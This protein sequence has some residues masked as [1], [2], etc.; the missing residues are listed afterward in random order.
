MSALTDRLARKPQNLGCK[1]PAEAIEKRCP[2]CGS[3][4]EQS[5]PLW[6]QHHRMADVCRRCGRHR[7]VEW[8]Y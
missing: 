5:T 4:R 8:H 2:T 7:C 1:H 6:C 3:P